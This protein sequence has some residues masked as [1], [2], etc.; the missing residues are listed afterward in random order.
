[1]AVGLEDAN[2][3]VAQAGHGPGTV[4]VRTWD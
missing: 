2:G 1:V 4:P 3:E